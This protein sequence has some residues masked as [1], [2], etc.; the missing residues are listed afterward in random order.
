M[1][2]GTSNRSANANVNE[3]NQVGNAAR[4][5]DAQAVVTAAS[6]S[7]TARAAGDQKNL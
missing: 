2:D 1:L 6:R 3:I 7:A 5:N 4:R